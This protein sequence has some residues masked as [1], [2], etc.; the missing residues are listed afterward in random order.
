MAPVGARLGADQQYHYKR[1]NLWFSITI[2]YNDEVKHGF[3]RILGLE[4]RG[5]PLL[6]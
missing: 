6:S 5:T 2:L 3:K 4:G 1:L